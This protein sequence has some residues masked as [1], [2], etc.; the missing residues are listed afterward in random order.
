MR[1]ADLRELQERFSQVLDLKDRQLEL[2][3]KLGNRL[4]AASEYLKKLSS[5]NPDDAPAE[6]YRLVRALKDDLGVES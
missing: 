5:E 1:E 4:G 3:V 6:T 2:L